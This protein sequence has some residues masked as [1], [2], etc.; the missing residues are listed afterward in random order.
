[1]SETSAP[2]PESL[3]SGPTK[4]WTKLRYHAEQRRLWTS[5]A[6]FKITPS[7][8]R[9]GKT[10][11]AKR[12]HAW[13]LREDLYNP[14]PWPNPR[15]FCAAPVREQAKAIFWDDLKALIPKPWVKK[16][17]ESQ[18]TITTKWNSSL[19]VLGLDKPARIEGQP[20]DGGTIDE[21]A[22]CKPGI[23]DAH[24]RPALADRQGW[25][26]MLGVPDRDAPGQIEYMRMVEKAL[27][28]AEG[29]EDWD[30]FTWPAIDILPAKEI[31]AMRA[32]M[33][34]ELFDQE[35]LGKFIIGG[36]L[37]FPMFDYD[38]HVDRAL[39]IYDPALPLC[40]SLDF[41]IDPMCNG[42]MQYKDGNVKVLHE[43]KI[44]DTDTETACEHLIEWCQA[45]NWNMNDIHVYGDPSGHARDTTGTAAN[46]TDWVIVKRM[47]K[48]YTP[49][50]HVPKTVWRIKD[51]L[52][53]TRA[54]LKTADGQCRVKIHPSCKQLIEDLQ[55]VLWPSDM[56]EGHCLAW[57]RYFCHKQFPLRLDVAV[58]QGGFSVDVRRGPQQIAPHVLAQHL[59][60]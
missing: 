42:L 10:E 59:Q 60:G 1:M 18:L 14:K 51:T 38:V 40:W 52:N 33:D 5:P 29:W 17:S 24:I 13:Q 20:W 4:R 56:S 16:I 21:L 58:P 43:F 6:R 39:A 8:R 26:W 25:L 34:S 31:A 9:G 48:N 46:R 57:F 32:T 12:N 50:V 19:Q 28:D 49:H 36:G 53:S 15:Y 45:N 3:I 41:N 54:R 44:R 30:V 11:I 2:Q 35:I 7:G 23:F 22:N 37:A 27:T 47:L 55:T